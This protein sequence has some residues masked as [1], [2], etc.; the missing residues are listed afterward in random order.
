MRLGGFGAASDKI[1]DARPNLLTPTRK[2]ARARNA[3]R[4]RKI[5]FFAGTAIKASG[6]R[7]A[8]D[9]SGRTGSSLAAMSALP[10]KA[11]IVLHGGHIRFV[12]K[13]G[14][15]LFDNF[16]DAS[17][18][19]RRHGEAERFRSLEVDDQ[20]VLGCAGTSAGFS[21]LRMRST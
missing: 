9:L 19:R 11:D 18:Y 20:R 16:F 10:P 13:S 2:I 21:P 17:K 4:P 12:A 15:G 14:H 3:K 6:S 1:F 8:G 7:S 5:L